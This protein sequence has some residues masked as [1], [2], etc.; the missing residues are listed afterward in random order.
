VGSDVAVRAKEQI[1]QYQRVV[2]EQQQRLREI[3]DSLGSQR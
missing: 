3:R 2:E 1:A